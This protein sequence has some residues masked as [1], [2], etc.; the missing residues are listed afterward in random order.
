M[1]LIFQSFSNFGSEFLERKVFGMEFVSVSSSAARSHLELGAKYLTRDSLSRRPVI[2]SFQKD[3]NKNLALIAPRESIALPLETN[4]GTQKRLR[5]GKKGPERV[6]VLLI[7]QASPSTSDLDYN[8]AAAKLEYIF[9]QTSTAAISVDE[10]EDCRIKRRQPRRKRTGKTVETEKKIDDNVV[11]NQEKK[12]RR[13]TLENRIVLR[14]K[15]LGE[16]TAPSQKIKHRNL[17]EG[18]KTDRL[19]RGYSG[20]TDSVSLDWKKMK[21]PPVLPS[22]EHAWLFKLI[23]PMKVNKLSV[24]KLMF[25]ASKVT[26]K[27]KIGK[28]EIC[29]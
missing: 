29:C 16:F 27:N 24:S 14:T 10:V 28:F 20:S 19:V 9:Q 11:R 21:M 22:S 2:L 7:D 8:E 18:E 12:E 25:N 15:K 4:K 5:K 23:Q 1:E 17:D 6:N 26:G 3:K 13:L